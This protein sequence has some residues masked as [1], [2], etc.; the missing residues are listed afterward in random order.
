M[1]GGQSAMRLRCAPR[2]V[3][4]ISIQLHECGQ[5]D[6]EPK[7][8]FRVGRSGVDG[9][10]DEPGSFLQEPGRRVLRRG[11]CGRHLACGERAEPACSQVGGV[12][13]VVQNASEPG[14]VLVGCEVLGV[15]AK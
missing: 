3:I 13:V 10:S 2:P 15:E 8:V 14:G 9:T 1:V 12:P 6:A 7:S 4:A 5:V 11:E